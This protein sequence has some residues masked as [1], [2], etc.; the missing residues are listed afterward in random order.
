MKNSSKSFASIET[1][2][3]ALSNGRMIILVDNEGREN[4]GDLVIAAQHATPQAINFMCQEGRGL[5]CLSM[6]EEDFS[7]LN[8]PMMTMNNRS[9]QRTAF[10]V[11]I[12]AAQGVTT[13]IS[14]SDRA[15]T[16]QVAI[17][18]N[19]GPNDIIMPGHIFPLQ[20]RKGG[21]L[22]RA[23]HTEGSVDLVRLAGC[24]SAAVICEIMNTDGSMA[25]REDLLKFAEKHN[26]AIMTISDLIQYRI[27]REKLVNLS[28]SS[29]LPTQQW[30]SLRIQTFSGYWEEAESIALIKDPID[31]QQ[32]CLVR[33]HSECLSGDIF[34]S[35]RCDCGTQ[36]NQSLSS[37][38]KQGGILLYLR[39]EGRGIGLLN[40]IKAYALQ[41]QGLDTV[42]ANQ[43]L[44]FAADQRDYGLAAQMLRALE[45][46][47]VRLL[48]NNPNKV[49]GLEEYGIQVKERVPLET[50]PNINNENYLRTK[51]DKLGHWLKHAEA[52]TNS[53]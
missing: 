41:D 40:K 20:A 23:G 32:P 36:L 14:V 26:L 46:T 50:E 22:T 17:D 13:G 45:I 28:A 19:T 47:Q 49:K 44:G 8:I 53:R 43:L 33:I 30:G 3:N 7:R 5:V 11:S 38:A 29:Y 6:Q 42:E 35:L 12:E 15:R 25:R 9:V 24:Q 4:E 34:G 31:R 10:G 51:R 2:L 39:Q 52:I 37:I 16:I 18:P 21:V 27:L 1:G 48:T